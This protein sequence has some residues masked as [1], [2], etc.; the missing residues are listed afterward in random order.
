MVFHFMNGAGTLAEHFAMLFDDSLNDS[1][2]SSRRTRLS[3]EVFAQLLGHVLRPL[4]DK[5]RQPES[6]WR[7]WRL[8][9]MDGTQFSVANTPQIKRS[10]KKAKSRRGQAAFAKIVTGVML[11]IGLH[12]PVAAAMAARASPNGSWREG[13]WLICPKTRCCW[14]IVCTAAPHLFARFWRPVSR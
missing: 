2:C 10:A 12:N 8:V 9:A 5:K 6:F 14:R 7:G 1:S 13:C 11:E 4:A 3:W